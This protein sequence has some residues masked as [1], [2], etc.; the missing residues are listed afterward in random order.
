MAE[1]DIKYRGASIATMNATGRKTLGTQGKYCDSDIVVEYTK[2]AQAVIQSNKNATPSETAQE[3]N[4]SSGYDAMAKVTVGAVS[5]LYVGSQVP[6]KSS[7]DLSANGDTVS[8]P[9]GFYEDPVSKS[10]ASGS[11]GTPT[12]SKGTV[13]N[14]AV[15]VTPSVQ[16]GAGY[17]SGGTKTGTPVTVSASELVSGSETKTANGTYD[18]TN[19]AQLI[20]N[21]A[22][23]GGELEY[24]TGT[25]SPS[26]DIA[27]PTI[28]FSKTHSE[29]PA[30]VFFADVTGTAHSAT[31]SNYLF[32]FCDP[33]KLWGVGYPYNSIGFR[34]AQ[35]WYGYRGTTNTSSI[36]AAGYMIPNNSGSTSSSSYTYPRYWASPTDF[37]PYTN[38][39]SRYWRAGRTYKWIAVWKP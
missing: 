20:V 23:G 4:P 6:R 21:V 36:S 24:E 39:T 17:I 27:R 38:N 12:A 15:E 9:A 33:Y 30:L 11:A 2:P 28:T 29:A 32:C 16:N 22:G 5:P 7:S 18:V 37:H 25:Y 26:A 8:V 3:I 35:A 19:L 10:V 34:Y 31:N 1:V 13:S 14:H